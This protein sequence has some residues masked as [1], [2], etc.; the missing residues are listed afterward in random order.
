MISVVIRATLVQLSTPDEMRGRVNA[1]DML[2]IG[3]SNEFGQFESGFTANG[4]NRMRC[5]AG[6]NR[7][8]T[9]DR[10]MGMVVSGSTSCR[11]VL[12]IRRSRL[13][14]L[15]LPVNHRLS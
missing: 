14:K 9:G 5:C 10:A 7:N 2:F 1:V 6:R 11:K 13:R 15:L 4:W 3:A 12:Q 8:S